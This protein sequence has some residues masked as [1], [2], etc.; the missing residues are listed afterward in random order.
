MQTLQ[1]I[2]ILYFFSAELRSSQYYYSVNPYAVTT[3]EASTL[4]Y[5]VNYLC[6]FFIHICGLDACQYT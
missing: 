2:L 5:K 1:S 3:L 4:H 6:Q